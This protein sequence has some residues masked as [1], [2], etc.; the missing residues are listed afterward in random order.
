MVVS[1]AASR[2]GHLLRSRMVDDP[3]QVG[4]TLRVLLN[5]VD[6]LLALPDPVIYNAHTIHSILLASYSARI[7]VFAY[8][9][10][11]VAA[12]A[13]AAVYMSPEDVGLAMARSIQAY[14]VGGSLAPAQFG[15]HFS[16]SVNHDVLRS[17]GMA[18]VSETA[19]LQRL[20][21]TPQ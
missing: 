11:M 13:V 8:S 1:E 18:P 21:D 17:L 20:S 14:R 9:D 12:G 19:L 16:V 3:D 2:S 4:H 15:S 5:D 10:P 6:A 7:P